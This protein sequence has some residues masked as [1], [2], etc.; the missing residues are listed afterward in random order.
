MRESVDGWRA[1]SY[2]TKRLF[3]SWNFAMCEE[4]EISVLACNRP[5]KRHQDAR[6]G[7]TDDAFTDCVEYKFR[8]VVQVQFLKD[9][10]A[11]GFN[12]IEADVEIGSN[13]F[14][15]LPFRQELKDF[16]FP[17]CK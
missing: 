2:P 5:T 8:G 15:R 16:T 6:R 4:V 13:F 11:M 17:A 7:L 14:V 9:V 10:A 1:V 3:S 12:S